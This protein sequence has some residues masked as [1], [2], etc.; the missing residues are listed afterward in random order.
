MQVGSGGG[1][2]GTGAHGSILTV[3]AAEVNR[4]GDRPQALAA[5]RYALGFVPAH[6]GIRALRA[7][8]LQAE[9]MGALRLNR[10]AAPGRHDTGHPSELRD[11]A[12]RHRSGGGLVVSSA[13]R[14]QG[15]GGLVGQV[16][17]GDVL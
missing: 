13:R 5:T 17:A 16:L 2:A 3:P 9:R 11:R 6:G 8:G 12:P 15:A 14:A 10:R 4:A 7:R 1:G